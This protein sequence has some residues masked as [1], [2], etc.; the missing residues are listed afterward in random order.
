MK[1]D[2]LP[3]DW[4]QLLITGSCD[5]QLRLL[6]LIERYAINE[7]AVIQPLLSLLVTLPVES[8]DADIFAVR[9]KT[10]V[11]IGCS[12]RSEY[13]EPMSTMLV[14]ANATHWRLSILDTLLHLSAADKITATAPLLQD[15]DYV[16]IRG[17]V[18]FLGHQG[19][20]A[21]LPLNSY[22]FETGRYRAIHDDL[23]AES[24]WLAVGCDVQAAQ[25]LA[26]A[27]TALG[28][29]CRHLIWPTDNNCRYGIYPFPDYLWQIAKAI[30]I[31]S[32]K[33]KSL[34]YHPQPKHN[35][36]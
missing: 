5:Q 1:S 7:A 15:N 20:Q 8:T 2:S 18:W 10:L 22:L 35:Y 32:A 17:L 14:K 30:G 23:I 4:S 24:L 33:F 29:F 25:Q 11:V 31:P 36:Y 26:S 28:R 9:L 13:F 12:K 19:S 16:F 21:L 3:A 27:D 34:Y 6:S